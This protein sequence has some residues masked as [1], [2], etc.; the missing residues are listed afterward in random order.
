MVNGIPTLE[1]CKTKWLY[2]TQRKLIPDFDFIKKEELI[3][4]FIVNVKNEVYDLLRSK[5]SKRLRHS[6]KLTPV[7]QGWSEDKTQFLTFLQELKHITTFRKKAQ[8]WN[9]QS[10]QFLEIYNKYSIFPSGPRIGEKLNP[11]T[12]NP[13]SSDIT[14]NSTNSEKAFALMYEFSK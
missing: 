12:S 11:S 6:E 2:G 14:G 9:I 8:S 4:E 5:C 7:L 3:S 13:E 1:D 10:T